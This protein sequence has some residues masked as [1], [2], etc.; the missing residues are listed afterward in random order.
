MLFSLTTRTF[1][2]DL[3]QLNSHTI[4][5]KSS[6]AR[7]SFANDRMVSP[8]KRPFAIVLRFFTYGST[9]QFWALAASMKLS[10]SFRLLNLEQSVGLLGRVIS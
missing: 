9:A 4:C 1:F 5:G 3:L 2:S 8:Q 7:K 6:A 10:V